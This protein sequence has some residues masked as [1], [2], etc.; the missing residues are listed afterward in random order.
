VFSLLIRLPLA[1]RRLEQQ[2]HQGEPE[3]AEHHLPFHIAAPQ[4]ISVGIFTVFGLPANVKHLTP[5]GNS[6]AARHRHPLD[7]RCHDNNRAK[8]V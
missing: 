2:N 5:G 4:M 3:A 6:S 7:E 8:H 1:A